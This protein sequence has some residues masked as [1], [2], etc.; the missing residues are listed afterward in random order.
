MEIKQ[1][2]FGE[3][4]AVTPGHAI[5]ASNTSSLSITEIGDATL[6]PE[7]VCGFHYFYPAVGPAAGRDRRGRRHRPR[8]DHRGGQLRPG[9]Q[10]A[11]DRLRRGPRLRR[12]PHPEL[13]AS[14]RSGASRRSRAS[15]SRR[16]T[17]RVGAANVAP[18][19]PVLPHRPARPR[20]RLPRRRAPQRHLRRPLLRAQ[21]HAP[22]GRRRASS[23]PRPAARASTRTA[24]PT[25]P[26]DGDP[27][28]RTSP[29]CCSAQAL[30][31]G[32]PG[33]RGGRGHPRATSTSG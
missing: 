28:S 1:A 27:P 17:R 2:V 12:Q 21:G 30:R 5:L 26:G 33:A 29:S 22:A 18:M 23:A 7:K 3:L 16:S 8:H 24:S 11:A 19:G 20:H 15:R 4:D 32:L 14:A 10:Q 31:R 25:S 6:R 9:D 13:A